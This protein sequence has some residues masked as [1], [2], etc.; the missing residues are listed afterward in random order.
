MRPPNLWRFRRSP[1]FGFSFFL[2]SD[3]YQSDPDEFLN[4]GPLILGENRDLRAAVEGFG[5]IRAPFHRS[6]P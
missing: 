4:H 5:A 6:Q 1:L 3:F 2:I